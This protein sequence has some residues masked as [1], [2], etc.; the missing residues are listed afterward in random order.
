MASINSG[1]S[2]VFSVYTSADSQYLYPTI[3]QRFSQILQCFLWQQEALVA[4][5]S[6][7][8]A[9]DATSVVVDQWEC[10]CGNNSCLKGFSSYSPTGGIIDPDGCD[11]K[12]YF[13]RQCGLLMDQTTY[14]ATT[15]TVDVC[16]RL[17]RFIPF[18]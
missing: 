16:G 11:Q 12:L 5:I 3:M 18:P 13:C 8:K 4:V 17:V 7:P 10:V 1:E 6:L 2:Q 14:S 15:D 9:I